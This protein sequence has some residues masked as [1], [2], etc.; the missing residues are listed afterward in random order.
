[1]QFKSIG[2]PQKTILFFLLLYAVIS[3]NPMLTI[4]AVTTPFLLYILL[5]KKNESPLLFFALMLQWT[6]ITIKVFY[7]NFVGIDFVY[8]FDHYYEIN[9]AYYYSLLGLLSV[10]I[11]I[12][13]IIRKFDLKGQSFEESALTFNH[14]KLVPFYIGVAV[15]YPILNQYAYMFGSG[16]QQP[17]TKLSDFKW[18]IFFILMLSSLYHKQW[19]LFAI[20]SAFEIVLSLTGFFSNFKDYFLVIFVGIVLIYG[21]NIKFKQAFPLVIVG[22]SCIYML[23]V[24]QYVK[25]TYR[26]YLTGGEQTQNTIRTREESLNKL[27]ELVDGVDQTAINDGIKITVDRLSYIDFF[28]ATIDY[29]PR[30]VPHTNG[31]LWE[32]AIGR[33][34]KPR[35]FFPNKTSIDDSEATNKYSGVMVAGADKGTSISLGYMTENYIDFRIP[36]MFITLFAYGLLIGIIYKYVMTSSPNVLVGTA[37]FIPMF[38]ILYAFESALNKIVGASIMY[39]LIYELFR[40]YCLKWFLSQVKHYEN[41]D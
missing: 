18:M 12:H 32:D 13:F 40:R 5:W 14:R 22:I 8:G 39:L 31:A 30:V 20:I 24:W 3:K 19:K 25:P 35:L 16:L 38:F 27:A 23:I 26:Q 21:K 6:S 2:V 15:L 29:V 17:I 41:V 37:M 34:L 28:S 7:T 10:A 33:V 11:G 1:M 4:A 9:K 36:G